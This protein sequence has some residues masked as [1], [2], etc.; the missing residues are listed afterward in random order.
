MKKAD[1]LEVAIRSAISA[2]VWVLVPVS[3]LVVLFFSFSTSGGSD[4][5]TEKLEDFGS[6]LI[7]DGWYYVFLGV[8]VW[9]IIYPSN[10]SRRRNKPLRGESTVDLPAPIS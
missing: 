4:I 2:I 9:K 8:L 10:L 6:N 3:V 7:R 1:M 5:D